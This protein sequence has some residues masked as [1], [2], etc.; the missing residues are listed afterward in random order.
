MLLFSLKFWNIKEWTNSNLDH[1]H[2]AEAS[3]H[4]AERIRSEAE[5][6]IS[7]RNSKTTL[8]QLDVSAK[9][10]DRVR[11]IREWREE[12]TKV[13]FMVQMLVAQEFQT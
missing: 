11:D 5:I 2:N 13:K 9:L 3:R 8:A 1:F 6:L 10:S 7:D 4:V 12:L